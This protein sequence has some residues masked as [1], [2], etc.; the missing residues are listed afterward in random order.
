MRSTSTPTSTPSTRAF[1]LAHLR[2]YICGVLFFG[3]MVNYIDRGTIAI[4]APHLQ[5]I[6][7]WSEKDYGWIVFAFQLAYTI[8]MMISGGI[9]DRLGTRAGYAL[10]MAWWSVAA[11]AHALARSVG[12]FCVARFLLGAGE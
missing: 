2:W 1:R 4:L 12:G 6:F 8:M 10:A 5:S 3:S 9:I 7:H 11:A